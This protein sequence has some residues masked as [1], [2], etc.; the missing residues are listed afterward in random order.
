[1]EQP[2]IPRSEHLTASSDRRQRTGRRARSDA[3]FAF[4]LRYG[5][6]VADRLEPEDL[7]RA[8]RDLHAWAL[9]HAPAEESPL[10]A[11]LRDHLGID[12]AELPVVSR[13]IPSWERA[14]LQV[15]IDAYLAA[16]GRSHEF[17]GLSAQHGWHMGLAELAQ[18]P[19]ARGGWV[20]FTFG[21]QAGPQEHVTIQVGERTIVCVAAGLFLVSG[22]DGTLVAVVRGGEQHGPVPNLILEAMAESRDAAERF[23]AEIARLMQVH[24]VY[25]GRVLEVGGSHFGETAFEVRDLPEVGRDGIVLPP[26]VL[27]RIERHTLTFGEQADRLRDAGR[28][29]KRGLLLH[30]APG[31]GKTLTAMYLANRM[32]ERTV[33]I[34]TGG[35][36]GAI[37]PA[38]EMARGLA[39]SMV[40]LEDVDLVALDRDEYTS[41][42]LLFELL[43]EMDGM[44]ADLDVVFLLTT[45]RPDRLESALAARP[46]RVDM[47]VELP[48]PDADGRRQ[49]IALYS[50]A[51]ELRAGNLADVISKTEGASPAFIRELLRRAALFAIESQ[52]AGG[53]GVVI[54]DRHLTTALDELSAGGG[55]L[56]TKLLGMQTVDRLVPE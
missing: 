5:R 43:N 35:G 10:R 12:P 41:N 2:P 33:L 53:D 54:E 32:P 42:A 3:A 6:F 49:L 11:R 15:A 8:F 18:R 27:E 38:C 28:H 37:G 17:V 29:V 40:V 45:N 36:L 51:L 34:L 7:A 13:E 39:P 44:Q 48:L 20:G 30:G 21:P 19:Q 50:R 56:T 23:L 1:V 55:P 46:G 52:G 4:D 31:T 25:R 16:D 47:A 14:N 22:E 26:G 24:N 9:A